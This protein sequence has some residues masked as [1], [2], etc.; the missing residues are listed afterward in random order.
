[1]VLG[2]T[3]P[4]ILTEIRKYLSNLN[5]EI[6]NH[7]YIA[8]AEAGKLDKEKISLFAANQAYIVYHDARSLAVML[9][10]ARYNDELKFF[11]VVLEGDLKAINE[12][13]KLCNELSI[14]CWS[15]KNVRPV[16]ACYTH[17]LAWL[18]LYANPGESALALTVNL[19]VWGSNVRRLL[20]AFKNKYSLRNLNFLELFAQ[21]YR[22]LEE[23]ASPII[24]RYYEVSKERYYLI[25]RMIQAYEKMFWDSI[26]T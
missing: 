12:L 3:G 17:Y 24:E 4:K 26:Y 18:A 19:P 22:F 8:D 5:K 6:L 14:D 2:M 7:P 9:S 13:G 20:N 23:L 1:M 25:A 10:K 21:D 16:A 15:F 11:R